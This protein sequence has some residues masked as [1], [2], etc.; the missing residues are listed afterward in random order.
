MVTRIGVRELRQS[1]SEHLRTVAA[2][3]EVIVTDRG[4]PVA[5]LVGFSPLEAKLE[6]QLAR[7]GLIPPSRSRRRFADAPRLSGPAL[8]ALVDEDRTDRS[9][10]GS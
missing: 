1:A 6:A 10:L 2:G 5:R 8:S 3:D 7:A 9:L 4:Q